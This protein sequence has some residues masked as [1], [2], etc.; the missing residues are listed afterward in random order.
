MWSELQ[1]IRARDQPEKNSNERSSF[2]VC[3]QWQIKKKFYNLDARTTTQRLFRTTT[4]PRRTPSTRHNH[5]RNPM[6]VLEKKLFHLIHP[7]FRGARLPV[8]VYLKAVSTLPFN[9]KP[10]RFT[11][12][13]TVLLRLTLARC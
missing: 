1:T 7:S 4:R 8:D 2:F 5:R 13:L 9:F 6:S 12:E 10:G 11:T 3:R